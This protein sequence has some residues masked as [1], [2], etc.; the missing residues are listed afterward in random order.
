MSEC[1]QPH[2]TPRAD[3]T[4]LDQDHG[5]DFFRS[6]GLGFTLEFNLDDGFGFLFNDL[7]RPVLHI[8]LDFRVSE[9]ATDQTKVPQ[10]KNTMSLNVPAFLA[11]D[12]KSNLP[13]GIEDGTR[14]VQSGL[15]LGGITDQAFGVGES[16]I[17]G[18]GTVTLVVGNDF[19]TVVLP[20][21]NARVA[22]MLK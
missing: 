20:D 11:L 12:D 7:E 6:E 3:M 17:R 22:K 14:G 15:V 16:N 19:N 4:Y 10:D 13:L 9:T 8:R 21:T 18:S 2:S 1:E 5:G